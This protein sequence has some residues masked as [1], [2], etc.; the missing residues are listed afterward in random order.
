MYP[1]PI[2]ECPPYFHIPENLLGF[3]RN[4]SR[5]AVGIEIETN[6]YQHLDRCRPLYNAVKKWQITVKS[7]GSIGSF[8]H[9][10]EFNLAPASGDKVIEQLNDICEGLSVAEA[11]PNSK[12]G[13]HVHVDCR[14]VLGDD[15]KKIIDIYT[16]VERALYCL[17]LPERLNGTYS[18]ICGLG[19]KNYGNTGR[20][21]RLRLTQEF[22]NR[23]KIKDAGK[24][25]AGESKHSCVVSAVRDYRYY[26]DQGC[27]N[28]VPRYRAL[29]LLSYFKRRTIEFRHFHSTIDPDE[30][31]GW[32]MTCSEVINSGVR[33]SNRQIAQL[34]RN[35]RK[36]LL[37]VVPERL[38]EWISGQW[39][40]M[41]DLVNASP[42]AKQTRA[43][44][45]RDFFG[46]EV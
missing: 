17:C 46:V 5:R 45:W 2:R 39:T 13:I 12:C 30:I 18:S 14:D 8:P 34:P 33:M 32:A 41:D 15:L 31:A 27:S 29:N 44:V 4:T 16:V 6:N 10:M 7:D 21:V 36:A 40:R 23:Q 38:H 35:S 37:A 25:K 43:L 24:N 26:K 3:R 42:R 19:Y 22:F 1:I 9:G 11:H 28:N 20:E